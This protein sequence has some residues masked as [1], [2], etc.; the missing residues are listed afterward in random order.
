MT[1]QKQALLPSSVKELLDGAILSHK[2]GRSHSIHWTEQ[3]FGEKHEG[4]R[5]HENNRY[6]RQHNFETDF[7][8]I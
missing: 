1:F 8:E 3:C 2:M 6:I 7:Q 5:L 4:K